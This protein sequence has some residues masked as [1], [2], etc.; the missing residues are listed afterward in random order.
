ME[1]AV[2]AAFDIEVLADVVV[3]EREPWVA[4]QVGDVVGASRQQVVKADDM[5][6]ALQKT[7]AEVGA[8]E[9]GPSG[10]DHPSQRQLLAIASPAEGPSAPSS[11]PGG[12]PAVKRCCRRSRGSS[13][14]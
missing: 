11:H 12:A 1:D 6:T 5:Q 13:S 14:P 3:T 10:D 7:I 9:T 2:D 8:D 4:E